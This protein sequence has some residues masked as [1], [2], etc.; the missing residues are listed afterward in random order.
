MDGKRLI[1]LAAALLLASTWGCS[2]TMDSAGDEPVAE[3][4]VAELGSTSCST[5]HSGGSTYLAS[6]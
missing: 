4:G 3:D 5:C 1:L 2:S 6:V